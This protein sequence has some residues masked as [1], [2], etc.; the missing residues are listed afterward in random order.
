M[1]FILVGDA[2][3]GLGIVY[4]LVA[5]GALALALFKPK[6]KKERILWTTTV[7]VLFGT[8]PAINLW[9][10]WRADAYSKEAWAYFKK[11]C[12][13][14]S[15]EKIYKTFT[16]VKSVIVTKPLPPATEKDLYD[17]YWYGDPYSNATAWEVRGETVARSLVGTSRRLT[18]ERQLGLEFVEIKIGG[19]QAGEYRRIFRPVTGEVMP[20]VQPATSTES[21]FG[22][23]WEDI[24]TSEDRKFWVAGSRLAI[25]DLENK[26]LVAE[27]IGYLIEHGF[28][29]TSGQRRPW[30]SARG[31]GSTCP[32]L[33]G[34]FS[35]QQFVTKVFPQL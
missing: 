16:G 33:V 10:K 3:R 17:Q 31:P 23:S 6:E 12:A 13:E 22:I 28:G 34:D 4:F 18:G 8:L 19:S 15:G 30:L 32:Q 21:R 5:L 11:M 35:D 27:R 29:S 2:L 25:I 14:K 7:L 9:E 20:V 26:S 24:S 1:E